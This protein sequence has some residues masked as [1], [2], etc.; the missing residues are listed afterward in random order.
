[1][2][3]RLAA[4]STRTVEI[5]R[6]RFLWCLRHWRRYANRHDV[7]LKAVNCL[8]HLSRACQKKTSADVMAITKWTISTLRKTLQAWAWCQCLTFVLA[9]PARSET[10]R[11][12][13]ET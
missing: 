13:R 12:P 10:L 11:A 8:P 3:P 6:G 4:P 2:L 7:L 5:C 1:L 9:G